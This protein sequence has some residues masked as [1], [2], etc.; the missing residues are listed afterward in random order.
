[1][2]DNRLAGY[3]PRFEKEDVTVSSEVKRTKRQALVR[4]GKFAEK[5]CVFATIFT[6]YVGLFLIQRASI[7]FER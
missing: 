1:V 6:P 5:E 7:G 3:Y 2:L 4:V